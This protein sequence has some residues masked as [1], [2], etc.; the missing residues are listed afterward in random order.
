MSPGQRRSSG[1]KRRDSSSRAAAG[2]GGGGGLGMEMERAVVAYFLRLTGLVLGGLA[3]CVEAA[4]EEGE[5][6]EEEEEEESAPG[7][8]GTEGGGRAEGAEGAGAD[9]RGPPVRGK[10]FVGSEDMA[11]MGLDVWSE[12]DRKF[13]QELVGFYWGRE[14]EVG[15]KGV[16]LCGV[17]IC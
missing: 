7:S 6:E 9:E 5:E 11:R 1:N 15:G 10:V 8:A 16:E 17:R 13:V 14:A 3:E 2:E 12:G 4:D